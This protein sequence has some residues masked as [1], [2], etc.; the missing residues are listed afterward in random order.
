MQSEHKRGGII[1]LEF[2]KNEAKEKTN[3][4]MDDYLEADQVKYVF[5]VDRAKAG[6]GE[7]V[8]LMG[9]SAWY[10]P[11]AGTVEMVEAIL[12][13]Q[14]RL[15]P[16]SVMLEGEYGLNGMFC[17]VPVMLGGK[18]VEKAVAAVLDEIAPAV[19]GLSADDQ[20]LVDQ[21]LADLGCD[22]GQG[23][24][25]ARPMPAE[26]LTETLNALDPSRAWP[27]HLHA[28]SGSQ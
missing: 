12:T 26:Q 28:P 2:R 22:A 8:K 23:F 15:V 7:V 21:L 5:S 27:R 14:K 10:A 6:G 16:C 24:H 18:G 17:G 19:I 1:L 20:R 4:S 25:I 13:D 3:I 11:S 9:T